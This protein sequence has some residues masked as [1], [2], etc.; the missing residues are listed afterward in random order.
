MENDKKPTRT[1]ELIKSQKSELF[2][3]TS[4]SGGS[5]NTCAEAMPKLVEST[6]KYIKELS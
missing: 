5:F 1:M 4:S 2:S 6:I 3:K